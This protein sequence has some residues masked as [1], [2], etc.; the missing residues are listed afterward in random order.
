MGDPR[1]VETL[2]PGDDI[3]AAGF[4]VLR[5]DH[6]VD[7]LRSAELGLE[8]ARAHQ[9]ALGSEIDDLN[10]FV[11]DYTEKLDAAERR[12]A[13]PQEALLLRIQYQQI[14]AEE[15][16]LNTE[17]GKRQ[18]AAVEQMGR[19][20][21]VDIAITEAGGNAAAAQNLRAASANLDKILTIEAAL[22]RTATPEERNQVTRLVNGLHSLAERGYANVR[23]SS[24]TIGRVGGMRLPSSGAPDARLAATSAVRL[25]TYADELAANPKN[26]VREIFEDL[27]VEEQA[28]YAAY[29]TPAEF[30]RVN[31]GSRESFVDMYMPALPS[32]AKPEEKAARFDEFMA[33]VESGEIKIKDFDRV[34]RF[35]SDEDRAQLG[36]AMPGLGEVGEQLYAKAVDKVVD[37]KIAPAF[38]RAVDVRGLLPGTAEVVGN[39][40]R[41]VG[42]IIGHARLGALQAGEWAIQS[43][44][45]Y[46]GMQRA[47]IDPS[48]PHFDAATAGRIQS[49]PGD[50]WDKSFARK[51]PFL[52]NMFVTPTRNMVRRWLPATLKGDTSKLVN[53]DPETGLMGYREHPILTFMEDIT[54]FA[55]LGGAASLGLRIPAMAATSAAR[56]A[57]R[58]ATVARAGFAHADMLKASGVNKIRI[59]GKDIDLADPDSY[60]AYRQWEYARIANLDH[61][62]EAKAGRAFDL[63]RY[64]DAVSFPG[65]PVGSVV[66]LLPTG[67]PTRWM[68][69]VLNLP[70]RRDL[71][72]ERQVHAAI[73]GI[74]LGPEHVPNVKDCVQWCVRAADDHLMQVGKPVP[75][76]PT[77]GMF[78]SGR[79][80]ADVIEEIGNRYGVQP[81]EISA[82]RIQHVG[83][84]FYLVWSHRGDGSDDHMFVAVMEGGRGSF[85]DKHGN[86]AP[87]SSEVENIVGILP[88]DGEGVGG[89]GTGFFP[90][91]GERFGARHDHPNGPL[92]RDR[93]L[94]LVPSLDPEKARSTRVPP[95]SERVYVRDGL[96]HR[97]DTHRPLE[98]PDSVWSYVLDEH[99]NFY[100]VDP[101]VG[102]RG[103]LG[104]NGRVAAAGLLGIVPGRPGLVAHMN[105][106]SGGFP[107][108]ARGKFEFGNLE[109]VQ[110][111]V[112]EQGLDLGH[113]SKWLDDGRERS[114]F[115]NSVRRPTR[116]PT[117][118][119]PPQA[120][121]PTA[122]VGGCLD[123][124]CAFG[125]MPSPA[126]VDLDALPR[127]TLTD[128]SVAR[129]AVQGVFRGRFHPSSYQQ[130][131][132][133]FAPAPDGAEFVVWVWTDGGSTSHMVYGRKAAGRMEFYDQRGRLTE[134]EARAELVTTRLVLRRGSPGSGRDVDVTGVKPVGAIA[135]REGPGRHR[136]GAQPTE[137]S[138]GSRS[139]GS[140]CMRRSGPGP[141]S[142]CSGS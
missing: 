73:S 35:L 115:R 86:L 94:A 37:E 6:A 101:E 53:G 81:R 99:G 41:D 110:R 103:V 30:E 133:E 75:E 68:R 58:A 15:G 52:G 93:P 11:D 56:A 55:V 127:G 85:R 140:G 91:V 34:G 60:Q 108:K 40:V 139:T 96:F 82:D 59:H 62:V 36:E 43:A 122:F 112:E 42:T 16:R 87:D 136:R 134:E 109:Q 4:V 117:K 1:V 63:D 39:A 72:R 77:P 9:R 19:L 141:G 2:V 54:P 67:G 31:I 97:A 106:L 125:A 28:R 142:R 104:D 29:L 46:A 5:P 51:D 17:I 129:D 76:A 44:K 138:A 13:S 100:V 121:A 32:N 79:K 118:P 70:A 92:H 50:T 123:A 102:H 12:G 27:T 20:I 10:A 74:H 128:P 90:T 116:G 3:N 66:E 69:G 131:G 119:A 14:V 23:D 105:T 84:G 107:E 48:G 124:M 95:E 61:V 113:V 135:G 89:F 21:P 33:A 64:A 65:H 57:A 26:R 47:A 71:E 18:A 114:L 130:L 24:L 88:I 45:Y 8:G 83:D 111:M 22:P 49:Q 38:E 126:Q 7:E 137:V 98:E 25:P 132:W 78:S 80:A 120:T